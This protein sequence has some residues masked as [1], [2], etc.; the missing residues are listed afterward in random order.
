MPTFDN[1]PR[2]PLGKRNAN[3]ER[4]A[5]SM[6]AVLPLAWPAPSAN[7]GGGERKGGNLFCSWHNPRRTRVAYA[8][9]YAEIK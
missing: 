2:T 6:A 9:I 5:W 7:G 4:A 1:Q 8:T 3:T